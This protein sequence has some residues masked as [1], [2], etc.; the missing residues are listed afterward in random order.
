MGKASQLEENY[1]LVPTSKKTIFHSFNFPQYPTNIR[2]TFAE[3]MLGLLW[4]I[5]R[6]HFRSFFQQVKRQHTGSVWGKK[7]P[8]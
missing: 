1:H 7:D 5:Q 4:Y 8:G 3:Q 2:Q 6:Q